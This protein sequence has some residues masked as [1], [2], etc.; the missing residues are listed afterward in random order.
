ML[1]HDPT[2]S[3]FLN[4]AA[5]FAPIWW[6]W[7]GFS[8]YADRF[9]TDDLVHRLLM[10]CGMFAV[11]TLAVNVPEAFTGGSTA[12]AASYLAV[13]AL[14]IVLNARAWLHVPRRVAR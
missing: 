5:L 4:F 7:V 14:V 12:F 2:W 3:G 9:D 11:A 10:M 1:A 8:L 13:R 6:A